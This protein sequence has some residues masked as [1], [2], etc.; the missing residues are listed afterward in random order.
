MNS[1][2]RRTFRRKKE[3]EALQIGAQ[4]IPNPTLKTE[5]HPFYKGHIENTL[6]AIPEKCNTVTEKP[7]LSWFRFMEML[8]RFFHYGKKKS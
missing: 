1:H 4:M 8:R 7:G 6:N 2:Q 5:F 3:R